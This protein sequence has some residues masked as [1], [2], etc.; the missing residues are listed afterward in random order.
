M[1]GI[2]VFFLGAFF[3]LA[4]VCVLHLLGYIKPPRQNKDS[5]ADEDSSNAVVPTSDRETVAQS[6]FDVDK[7]MA[8]FA[9]EII[10]DVKQQLPVI[11]KSALGEV[12]MTNVKFEEGYENDD[13]PVN[14]DN[15]IP[16][17]MKNFKPLDSQEI[18][19]AF[20]TDMRDI[21]DAPPSEPIASG[22]SL[23]ELEKA[24]DVAMDENSTEQEMAEAGKVIEPFK[25]TQFFDAVTA[26]D[27]ISRRVDLCLTMALQADIHFKP[28]KKNVPSET[29]EQSEV[30]KSSNGKSRVFKKKLTVSLDNIDLDSFNPADLLRH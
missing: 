13:E 19:D 21:D 7:F 28:I 29:I 20:N 24:M 26:D 27:E 1:N 11:L 14:D 30:E 6:K 5:I 22:T 10:S 23:D 2:E 18:D 4:S 3:L 9:S 16:A 12:D 8:Q 17:K 25:V 15:F